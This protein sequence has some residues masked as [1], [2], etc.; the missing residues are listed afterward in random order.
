VSIY[1][2]QGYLVIS[3][4][5]SRP[6]QRRR[7]GLPEL[8]TPFTLCPV[9]QSTQQRNGSRSSCFEPACSQAHRHAETLT[10]VGPWTGDGETQGLHG[11]YRC[12]GLF[13]RSAK[14][15]ATRHER[16]HQ[17]GV[18]AILPSTHRSVWLL[19]GAARPSLAALESSTEKDLRI[20]NTCR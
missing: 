4:K 2:S 13:L 6:F 14:P 7:P 16:K 19:S 20:P 18:T 15:L 5:T 12:A 17:S 3:V 10:H 8:R 11:S 1:S 9:D